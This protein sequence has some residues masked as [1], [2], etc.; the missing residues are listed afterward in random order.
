MKKLVG[1]IDRLNYNS[2]IHLVYEH[3]DELEKQFEEEK[4]LKMELNKIIPKASEIYAK[5]KSMMNERVIKIFYN[6][7][8]KLTLC[9]YITSLLLIHKKKKINKID[10]INKIKIDKDM[11]FS[12]FKDI[13]GENLANITL[14]ILDDI[15]GILEI[16]KNLISTSILTIR[17]Y[18]GPA[19]TYSVCK[20]LIKLRSDLTKEEKIDC[21]NQCEEV[22]NKFIEELSDISVVEK[23]PKLEGKNMF[24]MLAKKA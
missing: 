5:Y 10:V 2:I 4:F 16:N 21:K 8:L 24:I 3:K 19:F 1:T 22:L 13:I 14:K 12:S 15:I 23:S 6:E 11:L 18:I 17:Q 7:V 9:Y 20:K